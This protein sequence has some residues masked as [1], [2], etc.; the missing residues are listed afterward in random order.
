MIEFNLERFCYSE[1]GTF[2]IMYTDSFQCYTVEQPWRNNKPFK[3]CIPEGIYSVRRAATPNH[4][5]TFIL[6]NDALD[7]HEVN[8]GKGRYAILLHTGNTMDDIVGCIA[9]GDRLGCLGG[10]W[11]VMDSRSAYKRL[12]NRIGENE[13]FTLKISQR[14][15][16][17]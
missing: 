1:M 2:G 16:G 9:P 15:K 8:Q 10:I 12:D 17:G 11:S 14:M 4:P 5:R 7:V 6:S 3:S 13:S